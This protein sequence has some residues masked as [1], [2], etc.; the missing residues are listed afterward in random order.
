LLSNQPEKTNERKKQMKTSEF[1][2]ALRRAPSN[3]LVFVDLAGHAVHSGYH[4]TEIKAASFETVDCG[5]QINQWRETILQLWVPQDADDQYMTAKKFLKIFDKVSDMVPLDSDAEIRVEYGDE[6]F[7]PSTYHIGS[8]RYEQDI[9][10]V[11]LVPPATT[12]K[13]R[14]RRLAR[15]ATAPCCEMATSSCCAA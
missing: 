1:I 14:D 5:G 7:F 4:L 9:T 11:S 3:Q 2:S 13:A 12:C 15:P 6:N 8:V 10:R